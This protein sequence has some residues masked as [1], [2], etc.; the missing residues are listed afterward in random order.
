MGQLNAGTMDVREYD[1][2][3][4]NIRP[5]ITQSTSNKQNNK[6][7]MNWMINK[8]NEDDAP[9]Q[10]PPLPSTE[11]QPTPIH[12][13]SK[14]TKDNINIKKIKRNTVQNTY[15]HIHTHPMAQEQ[16]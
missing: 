6:S 14:E 1:I 5:H 15:P 10:I 11:I 8:V 12:T 3:H 16:A 4:E 7:R 9:P 2:K 13:E